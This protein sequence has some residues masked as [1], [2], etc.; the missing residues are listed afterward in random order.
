MATSISHSSSGV[1]FSDA[2]RT[3]I[4]CGKTGWLEEVSSAAAAQSASLSKT[5]S[6]VLL[7]VKT[8]VLLKLLVAYLGFL[9][10]KTTTSEKVYK[11]RGYK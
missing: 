9:S 1:E 11:R 10:T 7:F 2:L 5:L 6:I 4:A 8:L 3:I